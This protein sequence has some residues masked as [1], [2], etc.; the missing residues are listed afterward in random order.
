[1]GRTYRFCNWQT[2]KCSCSHGPNQPCIQ[3]V[4]AGSVGRNDYRILTGKCGLWT[5][6]NITFVIFVNLTDLTICN[7]HI[8]TGKCYML[9]Y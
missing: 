2:V 1:M 8:V 9:S 7:L 5:L 3:P 4:I 6:F